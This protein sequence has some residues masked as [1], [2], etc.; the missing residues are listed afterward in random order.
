MYGKTLKADFNFKSHLNTKNKKCNVKTCTS[1]TETIKNAWRC[2]R[3]ENQINNLK[4]DGLA[5][6][7]KDVSRP[8]QGFILTQTTDHKFKFSMDTKRQ[9]IYTIL[10]PALCYHCQTQKMWPRVG[11]GG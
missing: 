3:L 7:N 4:M 9:R 2:S 5:E 10:M 6:S 1:K 8:Q 11:G